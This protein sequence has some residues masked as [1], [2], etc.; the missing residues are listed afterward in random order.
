MAA[1]AKSDNAEETDS[2]VRLDGRTL[3]LRLRIHPR[4]RRLI[5][6]LDSDGRGLRVTGPPGTSPAAAQA[7]ARRHA[8][9]IAQRLQTI[10]PPVPFADGTVLPL[11]DTPHR[12]RH[13]P[14]A[15]QGVCCD[16]GEIRVSGAA[17]HL[18]RRVGD[19]LRA[20]AAAALRPQVA[21]L[22]AR[23]GQAPGRI[24]LRDPRSRWGSCSARGNLNF[25]WRLILAPPPILAYVAIHEVAHLRHLHHGPAFWDLVATL[26]E[27]TGDQGQPVDVPAARACLRR[28]GP[29]LA[30]Y[31]VAP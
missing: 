9:W 22:A 25:S 6:R 28:H 24:V 8:A 7:F 19:F 11:R 23:I 20:E 4:A 30:R 1:S 14:G 16:N 2:G 3:P 17:A 26:A 27:D 10:P 31:G 12:I 5:L 21:A 15:R 13:C 18:P 29:D